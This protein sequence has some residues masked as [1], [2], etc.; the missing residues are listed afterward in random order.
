MQGEHKG[1]WLHGGVRVG[2]LGL[3]FMHLLNYLSNASLPDWTAGPIRE[4]LCLL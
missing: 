4:G 1:A 2:T 3:P